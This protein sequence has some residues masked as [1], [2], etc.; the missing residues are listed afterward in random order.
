MMHMM[1]ACSSPAHVLY[2]RGV[3]ETERGNSVDADNRHTTID[4]QRAGGGDRK[5][6]AD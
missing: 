2:S 3:T 1:S 6:F 5:C 4:Y